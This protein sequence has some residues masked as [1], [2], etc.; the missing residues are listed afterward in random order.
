MYSAALIVRVSYIS[1]WTLL[2]VL[3][4]RVISGTSLERISVDNIHAFNFVYAL[5]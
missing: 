2:F 3:V 5:T 1:A 4:S